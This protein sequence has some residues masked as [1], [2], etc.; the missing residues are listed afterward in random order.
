MACKL[1]VWAA[2]QDVKVLPR[3]GFVLWSFPGT[4]MEEVEDS[5]RNQRELS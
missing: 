4:R 2:T 5:N 1:V 3:H